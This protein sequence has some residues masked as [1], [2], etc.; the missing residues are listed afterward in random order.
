MRRHLLGASPSDAP[1][2]NN[3]P[4]QFQKL[5]DN[6]EFS[7][8]RIVGRDVPPQEGLRVSMVSGSQFQMTIRFRPYIDFG[9]LLYTRF[10]LSGN[11]GL[12]QSRRVIVQP[13]YKVYPSPD[14][15]QWIDAYR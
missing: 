10:L 7:K 4:L 9:F 11:M 2:Q 13:L 12:V 6:T 14:S 5:Q 8:L 1:V 15:L 3:D